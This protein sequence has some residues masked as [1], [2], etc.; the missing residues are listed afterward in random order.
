MKKNAVRLTFTKV[1]Q[2][3]YIT[4]FAGKK[5]VIFND[6]MKTYDQAMCVVG[7]ATT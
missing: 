3:I 2:K 7:I 5:Y 4:N 6:V 1:F